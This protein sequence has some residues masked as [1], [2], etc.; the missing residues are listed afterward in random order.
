MILS[1]NILGFTIDGI[2]MNPKSF[3]IKIEKSYKKLIVW[4]SYL[5]RV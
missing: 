5:R 2:L 3:L 1:K 4:L